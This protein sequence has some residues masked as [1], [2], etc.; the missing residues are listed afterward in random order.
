MFTVNCSIILLECSLKE[1]MKSYFVD[2]SE[3]LKGPE[4]VELNDPPADQDSNGGEKLV[5]VPL[6]DAEG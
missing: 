1:I 4:N 2:A 5:E 6:M 3:K